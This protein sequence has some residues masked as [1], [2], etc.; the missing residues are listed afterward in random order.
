MASTSAALFVGVSTIIGPFTSDATL[1]AITLNTSAMMTQIT[2]TLVQCDGSPV[3]N[4]YVSLSNT[5][6]WPSIAT[7]DSDGTFTFSTL[8]CASSETF[9]L[10]GVD[11]ANFQVTDS[12]NYTYQQPVTN[13]GTLSACNGNGEFIS[14]QLDSQNVVIILENISAGIDGPSINIGGF[15]PQ[16]VGLY[17]FGSEYLPGTYTTADGFAIEGNGFAVHSV[18]P[19]TLQFVISNVGDVGQFMDVTVNGTYND[20]TATRTLSYTAHVIRQY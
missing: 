12:I 20:G 1:P 18:T 9:T 13:I 16:Q 11:Y 2:G 5:T 17:I 14:Y 3:S 10:T 6:G 8:T 4:G 15:T 19:N 7:V